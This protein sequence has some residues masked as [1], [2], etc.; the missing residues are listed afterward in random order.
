MVQGADG[1]EGRWSRSC[2]V[3]GVDYK[4][5]RWS[6]GRFSRGWMVQGVDGPGRQMVQETDGLE[7]S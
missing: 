7:R 2:M 1:R 3:Q 4:W 5:G 6:G